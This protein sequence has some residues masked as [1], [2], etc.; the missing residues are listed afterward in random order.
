MGTCSCIEYQSFVYYAESKV[1]YTCIRPTSEI[2][3]REEARGVDVLSL[4]DHASRG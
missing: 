4:K 1:S 3:S 2:G